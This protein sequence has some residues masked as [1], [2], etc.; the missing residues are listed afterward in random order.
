MNLREKCEMMVEALVG[1]ELAPKWWA[2]HNLAFDTTPNQKF[3]VDPVEVF[4]YLSAHC[5]GGYW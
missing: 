4:K 5:D 3:E 1:A 2:S